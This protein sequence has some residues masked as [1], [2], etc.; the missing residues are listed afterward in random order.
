MIKALSKTGTIVLLLLCIFGDFI[1]FYWLTG[2][3]DF[4]FYLAII[5]HMGISVLFITFLYLAQK[6]SQAVNYNFLLIAWAVALFIPVYGMPGIFLVYAG[7]RKKRFNQDDYFEFDD[8][9]LPGHIDEI[10]EELGKDVVGFIRSEQNIDALKDI[11]ISGN[12]RLEETAIQKLSRLGN[13]AAVSILQSVVNQSTTDVKIL[14][15]SALTG[16]EEKTVAKIE[17]LQNAVAET[18]QKPELILELARSFDLYCHLGVLDDSLLSYYQNLGIES[19]MKYH[20]LVPDDATIDIELGRLLLKS[21]RYEEAE[22]IFN[23]LVTKNPQDFNPKIWLAETYFAQGKYEHV[24]KTCHTINECG[25]L[26]EICAETVAWW[27]D[28]N[29]ESESGGALQYQKEELV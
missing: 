28:L 15:A 7:T 21:R 1:L 20:K 18:P 5:A 27:T 19:Y 12:E 11:F 16:I 9:Q 17:S 8:S 10:M 23:G 26:P 24:K 13:K 25:D 2:L 4:L 22:S 3:T 14:A 29:L 6:A